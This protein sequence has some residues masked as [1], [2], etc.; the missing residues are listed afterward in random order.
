VRVPNPDE[1]LLPGMVAEAV[2]R[3]G[4]DTGAIRIP[5]RATLREYE[6]HYVYVLE[7]RDGT[8]RARRRRVALRPVA[9]QPELVEVVEGLHPG[10]RIATSGVADLRDGLP[11][12]VETAGDRG[13]S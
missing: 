8:W 12:L 13:A 3:I 9:F 1:R 4:A 10:E 2:F 7:E 5:R 11:V 6:L